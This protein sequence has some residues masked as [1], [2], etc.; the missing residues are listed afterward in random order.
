MGKLVC[1][2]PATKSVI[3]QITI[4]EWIQNKMIQSSF[5]YIYYIINEFISLFVVTGS[6][7]FYSI[8]AYIDDK[9]VFISVE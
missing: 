8:C 3:Y 9:N 4:S 1:K 2:S 6:Q 5:I 7:L